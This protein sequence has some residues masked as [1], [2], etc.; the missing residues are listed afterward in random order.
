VLIAT[1]A[2]QMQ[3]AT[4]NFFRSLGDEHDGARRIEVPARTNYEDAIPAAE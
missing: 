3:S 1:D 2:V 4:S